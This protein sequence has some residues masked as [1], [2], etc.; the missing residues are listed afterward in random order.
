MKNI[1]K[2]CSVSW[3]KA[4]DSVFLVSANDGSRV[5]G[6]TLGPALQSVLMVFQDIWKNVPGDPWMSFLWLC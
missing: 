5:R 1:G 2:K 6:M 4:V 3:M